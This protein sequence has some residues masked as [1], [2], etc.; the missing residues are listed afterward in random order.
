VGEYEPTESTTAPC[1]EITSVQAF[2]PG[3]IYSMSCPP[4]ASSASAGRCG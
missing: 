4:P 2:N 3:M 1:Q